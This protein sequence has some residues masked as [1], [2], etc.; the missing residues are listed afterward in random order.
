MKKTDI[1][2]VVMI[3]TISVVTTFFVAR[4]IFGDVYDG[5]A[6]V[7][8]IESISSNVEEPSTDVFNK[9]AIN[10]SVRVQIQGTDSKNQ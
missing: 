1:T 7:K 9:D 5:K 6:T 3:A 2:L 4:A 10:P 8:T